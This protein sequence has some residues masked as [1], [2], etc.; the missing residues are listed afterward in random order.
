M[1]VLIT[2]DDIAYRL[3]LAATFENAGYRVEEAGS[4]REM[5]EK[6]AAARPDLLLLDLNLPDQHGLALLRQVRARSTLPVVILSVQADGADRVAGLELGAD[7][8][9]SKAWPPREL[10]ARVAAVLKRAGRP[11]RPGPQRYLSFA[12]FRL[13]TEGH[14]LKDRE[15]RDVALTAAQ[16]RLLAALV[17]AKGRT[18]SRDQLLDAYADTSEPSGDRTIDVL[19]SKLRRKLGDDGRK[20]AIIRT[21]PQVGYKLVDD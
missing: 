21:V 16:F 12:G 10:L 14:V 4:G 6:L 9:V 8:Y 13:D 11:E 15:G 5:H 18:L 19:V 1:T 17:R 3:L 20:P 2:D 7:D